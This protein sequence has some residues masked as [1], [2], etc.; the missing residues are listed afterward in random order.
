MKNTIFWNEGDNASRTFVKRLQQSGLLQYVSFTSFTVNNPRQQDPGVNKL[1]QIL[2]VD[3][4]PTIFFEGQAFHGTAA[5]E[6]L[7]YQKQSLTSE[8]PPAPQL[9]QLPQLPQDGG[10]G[11]GAMAAGEAAE[12]S[13]YLSEATPTMDF[14][15]NPF[16]I[17]AGGNESRGISQD[18][19]AAAEQARLAAV[20]VMASRT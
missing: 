1:L 9:P 8:P 16:N 19:L 2:E 20:P 18:A 14:G 17:N 5:F 10:N 7:E 12:Y 11:G 4:L 13:T 15:K 3:T 6:W